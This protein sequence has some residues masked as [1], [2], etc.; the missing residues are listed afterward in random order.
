MQFCVDFLHGESKALCSTLRAQTSEHA[1]CFKVFMLS[2][3]TEWVIWMGKKWGSPEDEPLVYDSFFKFFAS[4]I[5]FPCNHSKQHFLLPQLFF[6]PR[7]QGWRQVKWLIPFLSY[8]P[9]FVKIST[10]HHGLDGVGRRG[11]AREQLGSWGLHKSQGVRR[12]GNA[13]EELIEVLG[14]SNQRRGVLINVP[15]EKKQPK[16][17]VPVVCLFWVCLCWNLQSAS[18]G[19]LEGLSHLVWCSAEDSNDGG[20][21]RRK[22]AAG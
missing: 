16:M 20:G 2:L 4:N 5:F 1:V 19:A 8:P 7:T 12:K 17:H 21:L 9:Q 15:L 10:R 18:L 11:W 22:T 14:K 6:S 13:G 3:K